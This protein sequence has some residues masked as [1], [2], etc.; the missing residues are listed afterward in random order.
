MKIETIATYRN[1][2][3]GLEALI[4]DGNDK[5]NYRVVFRDTDADETVFVRF[6]HTYLDCMK[7]VGQFLTYRFTHV[8]SGRVIAWD[9]AN[10]SITET[11]ELLD[12]TKVELYSAY[13][14]T[15]EIWYNSKPTGFM[16]RQETEKT[17]VW[18]TERA[19]V[20]TDDLALPHTRYSLSSDDPACGH[21]VSEFI[22]DFLQAYERLGA[23]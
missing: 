23:A 1:E 22:S 14:N 7:D 12:K 10:F 9:G 5:H 15:F 17:K 19:V 11:T 21:G 8:E 6:K 3:D 16:T 2:T 13:Q 18:G 4:M 20:Q